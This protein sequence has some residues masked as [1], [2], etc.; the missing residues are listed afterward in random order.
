M[1]KAIGVDSYSSSHAPRV[2]RSTPFRD[3]TVYPTREE[4]RICMGVLPVRLFTSVLSAA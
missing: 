4:L 1:L 2:T 3:N